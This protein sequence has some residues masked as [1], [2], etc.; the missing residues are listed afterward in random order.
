M[1]ENLERTRL[2]A[3][4]IGSVRCWTS[5][6][7]AKRMSGFLCVRYIQP[8]VRALFW[9]LTIL[10]QV[11]PFYRPLALLHNT[12][13]PLDLWLGAPS[14]LGRHRASRQPRPHRPS[15]HLVFLPVPPLNLPQDL[16]NNAIPIV[17]GRGFPRPVPSVD[18]EPPKPASVPGRPPEPATPAAVSETPPGRRTVATAR[19]DRGLGLVVLVRA[20]LAAEARVGRRVAELGLLLLGQGRGG[21]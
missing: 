12:P 10:R 18:I 15:Q 11:L 20:L 13:L 9:K 17:L 5:A 16:I 19:G 21:R 6:L 3:V 1:E 8:H 7:T 4:S 2:M 14:L